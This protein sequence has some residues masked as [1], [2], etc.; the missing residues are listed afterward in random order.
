MISSVCSGFSDFLEA[1]GDHSTFV[2]PSCVI[3]MHIFT[4]FLSAGQNKLHL[5]IQTL[6]CVGIKISVLDSCCTQM[7][8]GPCGNV[9]AQHSFPHYSNIQ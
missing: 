5:C 8:D 3:V 7:F 6:G 9:D 2:L 4:I 1:L